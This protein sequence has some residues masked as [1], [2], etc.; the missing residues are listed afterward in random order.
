MTEY[1]EAK[2]DQYGKKKKLTFKG[3]NGRVL[4]N[5][6]E[7]PSGTH[8]KNPPGIHLKNQSRTQSKIFFQCQ[9]KLLPRIFPYGT[10][11]RPEY[12][13]TVLPLNV[14]QLTHNQ[15]INNSVCLLDCV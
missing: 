13:F 2:I 15:S 8:L 1:G 5:I 9:S 7:N 6:M 14:K 10:Y 3:F 11:F 4:V 12:A